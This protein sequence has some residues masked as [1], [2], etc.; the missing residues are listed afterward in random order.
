M[1]PVTESCSQNGAQ[2]VE[3]AGSPAAANAAPRRILLAEDSADIRSLVAAYLEHTPHHLEIAVDGQAAVEK[4]CAG[5]FDLV[6]MD[7]QMPVMDGYT[8]AR[9]IR[10][11]EA[12]R[13]LPRAIILALTGGAMEEGAS[14]GGAPVWDAH[15]GKPFR[16]ETFLQAIEDH[17]KPSDA[18]RVPIPAGIERLVPGYLASRKAEV[19]VFRSALESGDY[20]TIRVLGHNLKGSGNPYGF[21][22]LSHIGGSLESAAR[23]QSSDEIRR[24][25]A[26]LGDYLARVVV[27]G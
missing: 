18:I 27:G 9:A 3:S 19:P 13:A 21:A 5:P 22:T 15:L 6:L 17:L 7:V 2:P 8:A 12:A 24:Q 26:A 20:E 25:I 16:M 4:F 23:T 14:S 10:Q 1:R 11:W